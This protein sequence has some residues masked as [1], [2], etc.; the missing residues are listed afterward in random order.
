MS[1]TPNPV[2][3]RAA[4]LLANTTGTPEEIAAAL[5]AAGL[6]A[7]PAVQ[8]PGPFPLWVRSTGLGA[9]IDAYPLVSALYR[10][11][12]A[13]FAEDPEGVG[14][15]LEAVAAAS[16][17]ELDALVEERLDALGGTEM[18]FGATAA[19]TLLERLAVAAG[20]VFPQQQRRAG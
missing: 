6:L 4:I 7:T 5:D 8:I 1:T 10:A 13:E 16:G 14:A 20:P 19:H 9:A 15:E 11:H 2:A 17:A 12:A 3:R 18:R